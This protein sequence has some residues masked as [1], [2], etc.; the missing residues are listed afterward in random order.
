VL[1]VQRASTE[2]TYPNAWGISGGYVD[3]GKLILD[4]VFCKIYEESRLT[5]TKTICQFDS[6][7][8]NDCLYSVC[9]LQLNFCVQ[10]CNCAEVVLNPQEHLKYVW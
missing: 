10:V 9:S 5:V 7:D 4:A 6:K 8:S 1:I 3:T 2:R